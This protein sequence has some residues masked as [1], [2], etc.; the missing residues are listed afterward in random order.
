MTRRHYVTFGQAHVH[1]IH[2]VT[3][4]NESVATFDVPDGANGRQI[5][6]DLFDTKFCMEYD[7]ERYDLQ[8][9]DNMFFFSRGLVEV[10]DE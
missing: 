8:L 9:K 3:F 7:E 2:G 5:A 6:F 10:P 4:D 1:V